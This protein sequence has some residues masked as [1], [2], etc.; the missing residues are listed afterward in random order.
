MQKNLPSN[1]IG[2]NPRL[3]LSVLKRHRKS[4]SDIKPTHSIEIP[5]STA[6]TRVRGK[7]STLETRSPATYQKSCLK[8]FE[9]FF[10]FKKLSQKIYK[11]L[12]LDCARAH[13]ANES[14]SPP[15]S[16]HYKKKASS[17][18]LFNP[19]ALNSLLITGQKNNYKLHQMLTHT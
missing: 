15:S 19:P 16:H 4:E 8:F 5:T 11:R 18:P 14:L 13:A 17:E 6:R 10:T 9:P 3:I 12:T 1:D 2:E 7:C